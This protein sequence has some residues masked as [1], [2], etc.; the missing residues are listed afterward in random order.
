MSPVKS[1]P[2]DVPSDPECLA[3]EIART[4]AHLDAATHR[5]LTCIRLFDESGEWGRQGAL[6]C[7]HWLTWRISLDS[8]TAR[9]KVR[10]ARALGGLP[11]MDAAL[12]EGRLSYAKVRALT[13]VATAE[14]EER[15]LEMARFSTGAQLER[16]CRKV[17]RVLTISDDG[18]RLDE[19]RYFRE[20]SLE[21]GMVRLSVVLHPDEA[22]VVLRAIEQ[23]RRASQNDGPAATARGIHEQDVAVELSANG[24]GSTPMAS[25]V[26]AS[27]AA[28]SFTSDASGETRRCQIPAADALVNIAESYLARGNTSRTGGD[29]AQIVLHL[30]QDL[31]AP[32]GTLCGCLDDGRRVSAETLRRIAC[33]SALVPMLHGTT[34]EILNLGRRTRSISAALLRALKTRDGACR[35]PGCDRRLFVEAHHIRHWV[36]GGETTLEN[37]AL[38]CSTHHRLIHE[39]GF[40]VDNRDGELDFTDPNGRLIPSVPATAPIERESLDLLSTWNREVGAGLDDE[41]PYPAWDGTPMDYDEAVSAALAP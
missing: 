20:E 14:N 11:K 19:H 33:D 10:V 31:L 2:P 26:A 32:D 35:F 16:L 1:H 6:S 12:R 37:L 29:R 36:H 27:G 40:G 7:A 28:A 23:A 22:A 3:D 41:I 39:G 17:R 21:N 24:P 15:L 34:G 9:E 5:L 25:A 8:G 38:L 4:A 18:D 30:E 13:R